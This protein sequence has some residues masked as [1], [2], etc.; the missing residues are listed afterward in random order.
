MAER[1]T[2]NDHHVP[3]RPG[4]IV[5]L[6]VALAACGVVAIMITNKVEAP[7]MAVP[8]QTTTSPG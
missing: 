6:V 4:W 1:D 7:T 2:L 3:T 8:A 5:Y